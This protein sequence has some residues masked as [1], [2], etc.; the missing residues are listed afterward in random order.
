MDQHIEADTTGLLV[1]WAAF[2]A[3]QCRLIKA[4]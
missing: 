1:T 2:K 4:Q 3:A